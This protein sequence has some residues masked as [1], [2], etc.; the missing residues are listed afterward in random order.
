[1]T[2]TISNPQ[3]QMNPNRCRSRI[4]YRRILYGTKRHVGAQHRQQLSDSSFE[5]Q[6]QK[7]K[8]FPVLRLF[9]FLLDLFATYQ[10]QALKES[11]PRFLTQQVFSS[12]RVFRGCNSDALPDGIHEQQHPYSQ[13]GSIWQTPVLQCGPELRHNHA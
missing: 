2:I 11:I 5:N 12:P 13:E 7:P 9:S 8:H 10:W 1:M 3:P 6:T 4:R